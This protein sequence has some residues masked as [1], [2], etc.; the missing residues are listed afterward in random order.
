MFTLTD[1]VFPF[2]KRIYD[3]AMKRGKVGENWSTGRK[4]LTMAYVNRLLVV[5]GYLW[6]TRPQNE[7]I[8][9]DVCRRI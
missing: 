2:F 5:S 9:D 1:V 3:N 7:A 6:Q 8:R 4:P